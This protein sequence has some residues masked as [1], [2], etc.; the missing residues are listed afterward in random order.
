IH[1]TA[2]N[3]YMLSR[4]LRNLGALDREVGDH[5]RALPHLVEALQ[6]SRTIHDG[7]GEAEALTELA[8]VERARGN[9]AEA[10]RWADNALAALES[11]RLAV[12]SPSLRASFFASAR[13]VQELDIEV[14]MRLHS[15][16][17]AEGF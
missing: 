10:H 6:V 17:P 3:L 2:G 16:R 11:V 15:E 5:Q 8:R 13:D 14:L 1:R 9:F 4:T 12:A 7:R